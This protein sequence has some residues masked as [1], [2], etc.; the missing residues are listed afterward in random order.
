MRDYTHY[1][2]SFLRRFLTVLL[3]IVVWILLDLKITGVENFPATGPVLLIS[4]HISFLDPVL[5]VGLLPRPV[6]AMSKVENLDH[7]V[8]G[9]LARIF[10]A[11]PVRRGEVDRQALESS[12]RVLGAG[13]ALWLSPEG[14]R[15][16]SGQLQR[17]LNGLAFIATRSGAPIVPLAFSGTDRFKHNVRRLRRTPVKLVVGQ[18][19][20]IGQENS[21]A[22]GK[23]LDAIT[24]HA[25]RQIAALLP[26]EMRGVYT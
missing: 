11:F 5:V 18:P 6:V 1:R 20:Y 10:D 19:F 3:R 12:L 25:M 24:D 26:P 14:T 13:L 23:A 16:E 22:R 17:G 2:P 4:N 9:L 21:R 8:M 7:K 15:S